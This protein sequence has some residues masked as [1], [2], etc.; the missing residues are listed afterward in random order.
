MRDDVVGKRLVDAMIDLLLALPTIV[1]S[2][3]MLA[4]YRNNSPAD[5]HLQHTEWCV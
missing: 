1:A 3:A 5:L 4:L 2:L